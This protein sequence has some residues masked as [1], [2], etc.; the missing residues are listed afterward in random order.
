MYFF[1][2]IFFIYGNLAANKSQNCRLASFTAMT[3]TVTPTLSRTVPLN[4]KAWYAGLV[5]LRLVKGLDGES[6]FRKETAR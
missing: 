5:G 4:L 6:M 2:V 3:L 1:P